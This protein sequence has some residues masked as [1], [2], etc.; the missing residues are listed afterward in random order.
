M[1]HKI[2]RYSKHTIRRKLERNISEEEIEETIRN[3]NYVLSSF[4]ERKIAVKQIAERTIHVI[5]NEE[6][7]HINII[8][9][10]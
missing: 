5:Y 1:S 9:V 8:T 4:E 10:Y 2:I 3:P 7:T 6:K